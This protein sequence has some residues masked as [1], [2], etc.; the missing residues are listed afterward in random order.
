MEAK[1]TLSS[2]K[3]KVSIH[4]EEKLIIIS[5]Q[6]KVTIE[7]VIKVTEEMMAHP[8]FSNTFDGVA[9]YRF[10]E[11]CFTPQELADLTQTVEEVDMARGSWCLL[12]TAPME[13]AMMLIFQ[14]KLKDVHP[15]AVFSTVAAASNHLHRDLLKYLEE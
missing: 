4:P 1:N 11:V 2:E 8:N 7:D 14:K 5:Y 13:T 15:V 6:G 10:A 9:D 12:A 3:A